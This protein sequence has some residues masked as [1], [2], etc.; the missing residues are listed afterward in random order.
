MENNDAELSRC[1]A[2]FGSSAGKKEGVSAY[3]E[4]RRTLVAAMDAT[5]AICKPRMTRTDAGR[6]GPELRFS[7]IRKATPFLCA[8]GVFVKVWRWLKICLRNLYSGLL[9][10]C[11]FQI[12]ELVVSVGTPLRRNATRRPQTRVALWGRGGAGFFRYV[13]T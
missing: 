9:V 5:E 1:A 10:S 4:A 12:K 6:A 2:Y 11:P 3:S 13:H 7:Y 8:A